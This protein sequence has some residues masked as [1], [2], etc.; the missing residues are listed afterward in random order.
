MIAKVDLVQALQAITALQ[1]D[2]ASVHDRLA[3]EF[4]GGPDNTKPVTEYVRTC[5]TLARDT[6]LQADRVGRL[7]TSIQG[8]SVDEY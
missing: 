1:Q 7:C 3:A 8:E 6:R 4:A 5:R 2:L